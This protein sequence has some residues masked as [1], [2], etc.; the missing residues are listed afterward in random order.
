MQAAIVVLADTLMLAIYWS[1][2]DTVAGGTIL[3]QRFCD[4][5]EPFTPCIFVPKILAQRTGQSKVA[6]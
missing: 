5:R 1:M 4:G 6:S 2:V 3:T